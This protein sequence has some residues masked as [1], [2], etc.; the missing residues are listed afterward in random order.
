V[1]PQGGMS[2][3]QKYAVTCPQIARFPSVVGDDRTVVM[4]LSSDTA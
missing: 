3:A 4:I 1:T 2:T